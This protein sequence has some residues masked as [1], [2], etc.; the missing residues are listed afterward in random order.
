MK[1]LIVLSLEQQEVDHGSLSMLDQNGTGDIKCY[2]MLM[3]PGVGA[4]KV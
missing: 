2:R 3:T 4:N 1:S